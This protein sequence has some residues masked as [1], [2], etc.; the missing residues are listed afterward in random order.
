MQKFMDRNSFTRLAQLTCGL[1]LAGLLAGCTGLGGTSGEAFTRLE[2]PDEESAILYIYR[3]PKFVMS[4]AYPDV[5]IDCQEV[6][7]VRNGGFT[8]YKVEPGER[9]IR[10]EGNAYWVV[11]KMETAILMQPGTRRF[12]RVSAATDSYT[13]AGPYVVPL[14]KGHVW[15][16]T[17]E[18]ALK[19]LVNLKGSQEVNVVDAGSSECV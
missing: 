10:I 1:A 12:L 4:L 8:V 15:E 7:S 5:L 19:E 14:L 11:P 6:P 9:N 2:T 13:S 3:V 17:E 16:V 18:L